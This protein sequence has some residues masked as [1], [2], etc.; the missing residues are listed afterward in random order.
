MVR[1]V[2]RPYTQVLTSICTLE[3]LRASIR[4]S[5][6]F[7]LLRHSSPSF[8]SYQICSYSNLSYQVGR[9]C[10]AIHTAHL[11]LS[12]RV[13]VFPPAHSH[14]GQTP[15]SVFQDGTVKTI[16][17]KSPQSLKLLLPCPASAF[18]DKSNL[19]LSSTLVKSLRGYLIDFSACKSVLPLP[20]Q[21]FQIFSLSFQSPFHLSFTVL[22]RYRFPIHIQLWKSS[23][24]HLGL[25]F[26]ATRLFW[27]CPYSRNRFTGLA[28]SMARLSSLLNNRQYLGQPDYNSEI[29]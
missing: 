20:P 5:P 9:C 15:W 13:S 1:L 21:R 7:T 23:I 16:L 27:I 4:V 2:F 18:F 6:D 8:G 29:L 17:T 26:Q 3:R 10:C 19:I 14:I 12:F 22:V 11:S 28:P 25:L 24:S